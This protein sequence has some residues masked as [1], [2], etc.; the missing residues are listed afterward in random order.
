MSPDMGLHSAPSAGADLLR[1]LRC[2]VQHILRSQYNIDV[3]M[4]SRNRCRNGLFDDDRK[5]P[6]F[7]YFMLFKLVGLF[8]QYSNKSPGSCARED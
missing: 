7:T 2:E 4:L 3:S 8:H 1:C 5:V 6:V